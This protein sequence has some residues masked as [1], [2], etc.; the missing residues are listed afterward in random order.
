LTRHAEL[1]LRFFPE[2][3]NKDENITEFRILNRGKQIFEKG[4]K[5]TETNFRIPDFGFNNYIEYN[6]TG[7]EQSWWKRFKG[8]IHPKDRVHE[9]LSNYIDFVHN[10]KVEA[11][12]AKRIEIEKRK[13]VQ[14]KTSTKSTI[15]TFVYP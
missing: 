9:R 12:E 15:N 13:L 8:V 5:P 3:R 11:L 6:E 7:P 2:L 1:L 10:K 14:R 4:I